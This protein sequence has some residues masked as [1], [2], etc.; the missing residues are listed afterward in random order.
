VP[1][2]KVES[3]RAIEPPPPAPEIVSK[4]AE[5]RP[6]YVPPTLIQQEP[7]KTVKEPE[8]PA[9]VVLPQV[10]KT[11]EEKKAVAK[12]PVS[13][14]A[15]KEPAFVTPKVM[16]AP[17]VPVS[18]RRSADVE[19]ELQVWDARKFKPIGIGIAAV[20]AISLSYMGVK[21]LTHVKP[22]MFIAKQPS[23]AAPQQIATTSETA[24]PQIAAKDT[25]PPA[26]TNSPS[27]PE[28]APSG[29][30]QNQT[31]EPAALTSTNPATAPN[32]TQNVAVPNQDAIGNAAAGQQSTSRM[33]PGQP[34]FASKA[35]P[36]NPSNASGRTQSGD[37]STRS[38]SS[39]HTAAKSS[40][41]GHSTARSSSG[42]ANPPPAARTTSRV[43]PPPAPPKAPSE[44]RQQRR[45]Q[46][47]GS[48]P[49]G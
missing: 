17:T 2:A 14:P 13:P 40:G 48:A 21:A 27:G 29:A 26:L 36:E 38:A 42:A 10:A 5:A 39:G 3:K 32:A 16:P 19:E 31:T 15:V 24:P 35:A 34:Q 37:S 47:E 44:T 23:S 28:A 18:R 33:Q 46:F 49:G 41:G 22:R 6:K 45:S 30:P 9:A 8:K 7:A 4:P 11:R 1:E 12:A 20:L 43:A 25:A